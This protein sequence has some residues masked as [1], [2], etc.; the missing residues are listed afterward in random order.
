MPGR[1]RATGAWALAFAVTVRRDTSRR[2]RRG[3]CLPSEPASRAPPPPHPCLPSLLSGGKPR[4]RPPP[5]LCPARHAPVSAT[6]SHQAQSTSPRRVPFSRVASLP[7]VARCH[8]PPGRRPSTPERRL[9][10]R[11]RRRARVFSASMLALCASRPRAP[12]APGRRRAGKAPRRAARACGPARAWR[13]RP[14]RT[15]AGDGRG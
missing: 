5:H 7:R 9:A 4:A 13:W 14:R 3:P 12:R 6:V 2:C 8:V 10:T 11:A 15:C 1:R